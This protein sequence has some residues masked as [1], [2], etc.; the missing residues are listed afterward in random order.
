MCDLD[1]DGNVVHV[2]HLTEH[3]GG[4]WCER[5]AEDAVARGLNGDVQ[6]ALL[7]QPVQQLLKRDKSQCKYRICWG[8]PWPH[9]DMCE[10]A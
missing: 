6:P 2:G 10:C 3:V 4:R 9:P 8:V 5:L 1:G 7:Q